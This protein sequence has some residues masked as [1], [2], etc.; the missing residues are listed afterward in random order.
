MSAVLRHRAVAEQDRRPGLQARDRRLALHRR[1]HLLPRLAAVDA[2]RPLVRGVGARVRGDEHDRPGHR[3]VLDREDAA[4]ADGD[5]LDVHRRALD[6]RGRLL[7]GG[8]GDLLDVRPEL[9]QHADEQ[10]RAFSLRVATAPFARVATT[11]MAASSCGDRRL[12]RR[13][14]RIGVG[15]GAVAGQRLEDDLGDAQQE[16]GR[17]RE[18]Q[19]GD[20]VMRLLGFMVSPGQALWC[21]VDA[22]ED[23][24][25]R[26]AA[27]RLRE[28][29]R[30]RPIRPG[31]KTL[32]KTIGG[33]S[34]V[35][36][37]LEREAYEP[38]RSVTDW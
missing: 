19:R 4:R 22:L 5:L 2:E 25:D 38:P 32:P 10:R 31:A 18:L 34:A 7:G 36:G 21:A 3:A 9:P 27:Y 24:P 6:E 23:A 14:R 29:L 16:Q 26:R 15:E 35:V 8:V 37:R 17:P 13:E 11:A 30:K 12:E 20:G 33:S 28:R 1:P